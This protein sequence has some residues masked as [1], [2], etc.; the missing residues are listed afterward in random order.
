MN[1]SVG[2]KNMQWQART[3]RPCDHGINII[4]GS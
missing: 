2:T 1:K 4:Y 3:Y